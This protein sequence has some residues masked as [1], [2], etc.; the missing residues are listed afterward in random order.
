MSLDTWA[1]PALNTSGI[2]SNATAV[3][4]DAT[5]RKLY[6][7]HMTDAA[8]CLG[9][10]VFDTDDQG[11]VLGVGRRYLSHPDT[12]PGG[13]LTWVQTLFL[14]TRHNALF[15]GLSFSGT[16]T[17]TTPLVRYS[18]DADGEPTGSPQAYDTGHPRY[19]VYAIALHPTLNRLYTGGWGDSRVFALDLG[20][21]GI[22]TGSPVTLS[23]GGNNGPYTISLRAD[24]TRLYAGTHPGV[25]Q[26]ITLDANGNKT[27]TTRS[28]T[29]TNYATAYLL[30]SANDRGVYYKDQSGYMRYW[31]LDA[32]GEPSGAPVATTLAVQWGRATTR[33]TLVTSEPVTFTDALTVETKTSGVRE[34]ALNADGS[35]GAMLRESAELDCQQSNSSYFCTLST[36]PD[37]ALITNSLTGFLGN[38]IGNLSLR[39]TLLLAEATG[40]VHPETTIATLNSQNTYLR[41]S[42][43]VRHGKVY[44]TDGSNIN[45]YDLDAGTTTN[46][47]CAGA[48]QTLLV[49][50][51]AG[52]YGTLYV[53]LSN[54]N[55]D[56][57]ALDANGM[58]SGAA[59]V[60]TTGM[61]SVKTMAVHPVSA[62]RYVYLCGTGG[63]PGTISGTNLI[64]VPISSYA[65]G[66]AVNTAQHRLYI[67]TSYNGNSNLRVWTLNSDGTLNGASATSYPDGL[68]MKSGTALRGI[69][70]AVL[71]DGAKNRLYIAGY[72]E[73]RQGANQ[74]W[75]IVHTLDANGDPSGT[76]RL[77][78]SPNQ[79]GSN[80]ALALSPDCTRIYMGGWGDPRVFA[81][82]LNSNGEPTGDEP[83][84][85]TLSSSYGPMG[86]LCATA[87]GSL[88]LAGP[89]RRCSTS[90]A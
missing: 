23:L 56:V 32:S 8:Q 76:P 59:N 66:A 1:V 65:N 20:A 47:A 31:S 9:L 7:G 82:A 18:L 51:D 50:D 78:P 63:T 73:T 71:Y 33:N 39:T 69:L 90:C 27:G 67:V 68:P 79:M 89:T 64:R 81:Q 6:V 84:H 87:D 41:F 57:R 16:S 37:V 26:V 48:S 62:A 49:D 2:V 19:T 38:R 70:P 10:T 29:A 43:S 3:A 22:P 80:D 61:S 60:I 45:V 52:T 30:M 58:P 55:V 77:Y 54:G 14:D 35:L 13:A 40:E 36:E 75:L 42:H 21:D 88:L 86:G 72:P 17:C 74:S 53:A 5:K 4:Y 12:Q 24:G 25:L 46:V 34:Y 44:A 83:L 85:W 28:Y 11:K 15:I